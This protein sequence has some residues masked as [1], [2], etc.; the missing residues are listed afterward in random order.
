MARP[1]NGQEK[2]HKLSI[3]QSRPNGM[4]AGETVT[5]PIDKRAVNERSM[6]VNQNLDPL[7]EQH[8]AR[9]G[10][11]QYYQRWPPAFPHKKQQQRQKNDADPLPR[12][13]FGECV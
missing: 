5:R 4:A 6:A 7:V 12:T 13:K 1:E 11:D 8:A 3:K 2:Q 9:D 10:D